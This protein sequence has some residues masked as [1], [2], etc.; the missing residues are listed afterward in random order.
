VKNSDIRH[1]ALH[2]LSAPSLRAL[3]ILNR[4]LVGNVDQVKCI[5]SSARP[6]STT[7]VDNGLRNDARQVYQIWQ[8]RQACSVNYWVIQLSHKEDNENVIVQ[9]NVYPA[10]EAS[11]LC[12]QSGLT[13]VAEALIGSRGLAEPQIS[14]N[15]AELLALWLVR[16]G[17]AGPA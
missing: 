13:E 8:K 2:F 16:R 4:L 17:L 12:K 11:P 7:R 3:R 15:L 1:N 6:Q 10:R 5:S 9:P 14:V